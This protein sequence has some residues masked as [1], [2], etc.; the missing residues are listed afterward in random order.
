VTLGL[1]LVL[2]SCGD[3]KSSGS[4]TGGAKSEVIALAADPLDFI[5]PLNENSSPG[6]QVA[7][8]MFAPLDDQAE[9][10]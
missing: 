9:G 10:R 6:I 3:G 5:N 7:Q 4:G 1:A 2:T 8:A